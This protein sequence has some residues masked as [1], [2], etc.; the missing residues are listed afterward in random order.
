MTNWKAGMKVVCVKAHSQGVLKVNGTYT[1][2]YTTSCP[3]CGCAKLT[4][5]IMATAPFNYCYCGCVRESQSEWLFCASLFRPLITEDIDQ[6]MDEI[7]RAVEVEQL[8][9]VEN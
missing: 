8:E 7:E 9:L 2:T 5:G 6:Q 1:V 4:V 3:G